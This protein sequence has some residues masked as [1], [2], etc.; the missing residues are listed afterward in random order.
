MVG[1]AQT[2]TSVDFR[3]FP[4]HLSS[5]KTYH[6]QILSTLVSYEE[7]GVGFETI[8]NGEIFGMKNNTEKKC[9]SDR[10][11][12]RISSTDSKV[13]TTLY[14]INRTTGKYC[15]EEIWM[16]KLQ[17]FITELIKNHL[18]EHNKHHEYWSLAFDELAV[19]EFY[20]HIAN[21]IVHAGVQVTLTNEV[22]LKFSLYQ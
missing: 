9:C 15:S 8:R 17:D 7:L 21:N 1:R 12:F 19:D 14:R 2:P 6:I 4:A 18:A 3:D 11:H 22:W 10:S 20:P 5:L 16:V 13:R